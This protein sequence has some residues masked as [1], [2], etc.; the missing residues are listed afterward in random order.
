MDLILVFLPLAL[1]WVTLR[2]SEERQRVALLGSHLQPLRIEQRMSQLTDAYLRAVGETDPSRAEVVWQNLA[3]TEHALRDDLAQLATSL[4]SVWGERMR[5]CRWPV[6]VPHATRFFPQS[7]FDFR[8]LVSLHAQGL[9]SVLQNDD[10]LSRRDRAF[11]ATAELLLFQHS[12]HWFCR[13]KNVASTRLLARHRTTHEQV[14][15]AVSPVTRA[16]YER[17]TTRSPG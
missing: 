1:A 9:A 14:L 3:A 10:G 4:E 13:S 17:L 11:R 15:A 6:G 16:A 12:C 2:R 8:A 5:V 7:S